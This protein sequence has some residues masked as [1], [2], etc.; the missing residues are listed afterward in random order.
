MAF[1]RRN[2]PPADIQ[3]LM[4]PWFERSYPVYLQRTQQG[5]RQFSPLCS[6]AL[7]IKKE[8]F[9][10]LPPEQQAQVAAIF[11]DAEG[12]WAADGPQG[13]FTATQTGGGGRPVFL[14]FL[15]EKPHSG[16]RLIKTFK[17]GDKGVTRGTFCL[18][19]G[20]KLRLVAKPDVT[21][22]F[23]TGHTPTDSG[24][25]WPSSLEF[26]DIDRAH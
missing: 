5:S 19:T 13:D 21:A 18:A 10:A 2:P 8:V 3:Q 9:D 14:V 15:A 26:A 6:C 16:E 4:A 24:E 20:G 12:A 17:G 1:P 22:K 23:Y 11:R 25:M 7:G